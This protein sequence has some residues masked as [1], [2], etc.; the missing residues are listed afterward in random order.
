MYRNLNKRDR[1]G[2]KIYKKNKK[3]KKKKTE[4]NKKKKKKGRCQTKIDIKL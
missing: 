1:S 2:K 4:K 3:K